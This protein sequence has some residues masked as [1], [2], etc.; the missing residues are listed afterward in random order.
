[1]LAYSEY[2]IKKSVFEC[3]GWL[4]EGQGDMQNDPRSGQPKMQRQM[5]M[6]TEFKR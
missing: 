6:W 3:H 2:A 1:M 5:Q 4:K